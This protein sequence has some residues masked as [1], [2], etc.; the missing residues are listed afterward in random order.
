MDRS[1]NDMN[2]LEARLG[3]WRPA[4]STIDRDRVMFLAGKASAGS[5]MRGRIAGAAI[6]GLALLAA[7]MGGMWANERGH[8]VRLEAIAAERGHEEEPSR[9]ETASNPN[10]AP[11]APSSYLVLSHRPEMMEDA[12]LAASAPIPPPTRGPLD[13]EPT[14][15]PMSSRSAELME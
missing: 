15:S 13:R 1:E 3:A 2:A 8:R 12:E 5:E 4:A 9:V 7:G 11:L 6:V 14:L 10:P